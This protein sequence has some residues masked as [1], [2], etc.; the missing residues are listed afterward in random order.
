M[1]LV[2][3]VTSALAGLV[4]ARC[5]RPPVVSAVAPLDL[6]CWCLSTHNTPRG[7]RC[8]RGSVNDCIADFENLDIS[9]SN[10]RCIRDMC[11]VECAPLALLLPKREDLASCCQCL[12]DTRSEGTACYNGTVEQCTDELDEG[13]PNRILQGGASCIG[14]ACA[15]ACAALFGLPADAGFPDAAVPTVDAAVVELPDASVVVRR[16]GGGRPHLPWDGGCPL[17]FGCY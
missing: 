9:E 12:V 3:A 7:A 10:P 15:P 4:A 8:T 2:V 11:G 1:T 5:E 17:E 14:G 6:C 16:D 13:E